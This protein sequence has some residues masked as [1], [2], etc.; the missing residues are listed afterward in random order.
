[1]KSGAARAILCNAGNA[2]CCNG[3]RGDFDNRA[4]AEHIANHLGIAREH[5]LTASTGII[6]K[7]LPLAPIRYAVEGIRA[8][9][10]RGPDVDAEV[11]RAIMTTD[12]RPKQIALECGSPDWKQRDARFKYFLNAAL[13]LGEMRRRIRIKFGRTLQRRVNPRRQ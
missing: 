5:V 9:L 8:K 2:N 4:M 12:T 10:R 6:G 11:A 7:P 1:M 3:E 13:H